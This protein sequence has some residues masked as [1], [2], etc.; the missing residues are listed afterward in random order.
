[1]KRIIL[2]LLKSILIV[3]VFTAS[4]LWGN[5]KDSSL[6][7]SHEIYSVPNDS[8]KFYADYTFIDKDGVR[9]TDQHIWDRIFKLINGSS[10]YMLF[11]FFL[12]NEFQSFTQENTRKLSGELTSHIIERRAALGHIPISFITDPINTV[13]G[14]VFSPQQIRLRKAGIVTTET[15]LGILTDS[16]LLVA[17]FW[18]PF[19][20]LLGNSQEGGIFPHPFQYEGDKVTLRSWMSLLNFKANHRKIMIVDEPSPQKG[21]SS[22]RIKMVTV[23]TSSNPHDASSAHGNI[24]LE[25]RDSIW[26]DV[27]ASEAKIAELSGGA[28]INFNSDQVSDETG[29]IQV[30]LLTEFKIRDE[31]LRLLGEAKQ[32]DKIELAMFYLSQREIVKALVEASNH[33]AIVRVILDPNKDAF[34]HKKNGIPNVP[35]AKELL[36]KSSGA[37]TTRWC[38][39]HGEQ[40][41]AK[42]FTG[43]INN[44]HFLMVGSAN[45][46]RR[47]ID[48]Y[49]L[50]TDILAQSAEPF[51]AW[52]EAQDYFNKMWDNTD[53]IFTTDYKTYADDTFWKSSLYRIMEY[54]GL[55][56]F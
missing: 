24:A 27:I 46:T 33:G 35:V 25:V 43:K 50:E 1:M 17:S 18:R 42:L 36:S 54:T 5:P 26:K 4:F 32:G 7:L 38:D 20:S 55:S 22:P 30:Q 53:G 31:V 21:A 37:I 9:V 28:V 34:G 15:D 47:N 12:F 6:T 10:H 44:Q 49:N 52:N 48:G 11:D 41:H 16:N 51:T 14:G 3:I 40:C 45:F 8:V 19:F 23:V 39:T 56:T 29:T 13:Y 2:G